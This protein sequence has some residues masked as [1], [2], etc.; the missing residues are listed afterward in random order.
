MHYVGLTDD[1]IE[2]LKNV[3]DSSGNGMLLDIATHHQ[4]N[5]CASLNQPYVYYSLY[6]L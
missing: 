3:I 2:D 1:L 4:L 6:S 5:Q